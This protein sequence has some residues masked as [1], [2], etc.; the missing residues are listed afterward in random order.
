MSK[1]EPSPTHAHGRQGMEVAFGLYSVQRSG[2]FL[3][4]H[5]G[6]LVVLGRFD[7]VAVKACSGLNCVPTLERNR[8]PLEHAFLF[9][10][11]DRRSE[12]SSRSLTES[13]LKGVPP[14][15]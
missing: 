1:D 2:I 11:L 15:R 9:P 12:S 3:K 7:L 14:K 10:R 4:A 5:P 8:S 13:W 6:F